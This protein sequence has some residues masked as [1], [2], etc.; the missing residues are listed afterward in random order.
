M[1]YD[2]R[3]V[4]IFPLCLFLACTGGGSKADRPALG[5]DSGPGL[6]SPDSDPTSCTFTTTLTSDGLVGEVPFT[7]H[8]EAVPSCADLEEA[9]WDFGDGETESGAS[10]SHTWLASGSYTVTVDARDPD[11]DES[12]A[13]LPI[14]VE[15]ASCPE[16]G[17]S[18][19]VGTIGSEDLIEASG[20]AAGIANVGVLW[21]HNDSGD[22]P[23]LYAMD[24]TGADLGTFRLDGAPDGDWEDLAIGLDDDGV[25][26]LFAG[27]IEIGRAHV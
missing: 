10:V 27:D 19:E 9:T 21:S 1:R 3:R 14:E 24:E 13:S 25:P 12:T 2:R 7:V 26:V 17:E 8:F 11:G 6:D 16:V 22:G 5:D 18:T 23:I 20:I 4:R 15:T